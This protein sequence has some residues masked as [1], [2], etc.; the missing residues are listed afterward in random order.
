M[1]LVIDDSPEDLFFHRRMIRKID[2]G[3]EIMDF[4]YAEDALNYIGSSQDGFITLILL[5]INLPRIDGFEFLLRYETL[6]AECQR[7]P[8]IYVMSGSI[9]PND[10]QHANRLSMVN[11]YLAKPLREGVLRDVLCAADR[12]ETVSGL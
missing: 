6:H 9:D 11:G 5:D 8:A 2:P 7:S 3:A 10:R 12:P 4:S 1:I